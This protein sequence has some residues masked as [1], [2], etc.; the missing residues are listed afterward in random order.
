MKK[1]TNWFILL[2]IVV[3]LLI[4]LSFTSLTWSQA[5][6]YLPAANLPVDFR[7]LFTNTFT[8]SLNQ[9]WQQLLF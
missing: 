4:I 3:A 8:G 7:H 9:L 1:H 2:G 5:Q 6:S